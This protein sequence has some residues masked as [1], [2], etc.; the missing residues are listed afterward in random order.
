[1]MD[2]FVRETRAVVDGP[3]AMI[4]YNNHFPCDT[5]IVP[6]FSTHLLYGPA[7]LGPVGA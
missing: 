6:Y 7:D 1:M 2:F 3:M 5:R 4:R